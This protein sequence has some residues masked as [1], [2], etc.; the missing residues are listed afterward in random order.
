LTEIANNYDR[1]ERNISGGESFRNPAL[2]IRGE[3]SDFIS[4][5]DADAIRNLF[6]SGR[7]H[8]IAGAG[9][10]LHVEKTNEFISV[11]LEFLRSPYESSNL[12][13]LRT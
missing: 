3:R 6:P 2:F 1:L 11:L 8:T 13:S 4:E 10:L 9:H 7:L 5:G 12:F